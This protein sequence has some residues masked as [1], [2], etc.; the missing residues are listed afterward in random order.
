MMFSESAPNH[1][2]Q[3]RPV[4]ALVSLLLLGTLLGCSSRGDVNIQQMPP[5]EAPTC[6]NLC[7]RVTAN[8]A[9]FDGC[10]VFASKDRETC[11]TKCKA[12][13]PSE[14][15]LRCGMM[16]PNCEALD[17]CHQ[18]LARLRAP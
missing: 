2:T 3:N 6:V 4:L 16:S 1:E 5:G 9:D 12:V 14:E 17:N 10:G 15:D 7:G 13:A 8:D 11:L 18:L